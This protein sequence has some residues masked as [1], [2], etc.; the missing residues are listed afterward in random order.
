[1]LD[2]VVGGGFRLPGWGASAGVVARARGIQEIADGRLV[3]GL[4]EQTGGVLTAANTPDVP[5]YWSTSL[6]TEAVT[7]N[8]PVGA[9]GDPDR[10]IEE[11]R[12]A[13]GGSCSP[14]AWA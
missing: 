14:P 12:L 2:V 9:G 1:M 8:V 11:L 10:P 6:F 3:L 4:L 5:L 13:Q 7:T